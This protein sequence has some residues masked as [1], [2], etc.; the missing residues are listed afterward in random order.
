MIKNGEGSILYFGYYDKTAENYVKVFSDYSCSTAIRTAKEFIAAMLNQAEL[1]CRDL[2]LHC[3]FILD[4]KSGKPIDVI[5]DKEKCIFVFND[6]INVLEKSE[7][8]KN[9]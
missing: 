8:V 4:T 2:E 3:L 6:Y 1:F 5:S 9:G 7:D